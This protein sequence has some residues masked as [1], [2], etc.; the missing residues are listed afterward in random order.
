MEGPLKP[1]WVNNIPSSK[2]VFLNET[3]A[4]TDNPV[5]SL[6]IASI[7][8]LKVKGTS[9]GNVSITFKLNF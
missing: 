1:L 2:K 4:S 5:S 8:S 7:F 6:Q 3:T 9:A